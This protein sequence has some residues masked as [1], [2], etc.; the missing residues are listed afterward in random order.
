MGPAAAPWRRCLHP[1]R[2]SSTRR[3]D[4][5]AALR[6]L[7]ASRAARRPKV[8]VRVRDGT[9]AHAE[10]PDGETVRR[11][12]RPLSALRE[13]PDRGDPPADQR[14]VERRDRDATDD[15]PGG[16]ASVRQGGGHDRR[17]AD[18]DR[19]MN[20]HRG[21]QQH[22]CTPLMWEQH[23]AGGAAPLQY[24]LAPEQ[25]P[26]RGGDGRTRRSS[27][28]G[29]QRVARESSSKTTPHTNIVSGPGLVLHAHAT[30]PK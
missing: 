9:V 29:C 14:Q 19:E 13:R 15:T 4:T 8:R 2:R 27:Q 1:R 7:R 17:P 16:L 28:P 18:R 21:G 12:V 11:V 6:R 30:R 10:Q 22:R 3:E 25:R 5:S 24:V 26:C 23:R 20:G